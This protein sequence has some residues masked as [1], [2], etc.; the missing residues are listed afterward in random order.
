[1]HWMNQTSP[2]AS[3]VKKA[4]PED[5]AVILDWLKREYDEDGSGFWSNRNII[6][7]ALEETD[8]LWVIRRGQ[9]A[10]AFQ[11]GDHAADIVSV[12]KDLRGSGYGTALFEASLQRAMR[13][14]V[15]VLEGE[16]SPRSSLTYW[17]GHGFEQYQD[18]NRPHQVMLRRILPRLYDLPPQAPRVE[19]IIS[20][21]PEEAQYYGRPHV[22]PVARHHVIGARLA[23]GSIQLE[24]RVLGLSDDEPEGGDLTVKVEVDGEE[25]CFCKAKYEEAAGVGIRRGKSGEFFIDVVET[26]EDRS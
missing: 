9:Q 1:M 13:H 19:V 25:R 24:R 16:C 15:N 7:R 20:F 6:T 5:L 17:Q 2:S 3:D 21:Y 8:D 22:E 23:D 26:V 10:V 12:R 14:E 18:R 11:V 4:R